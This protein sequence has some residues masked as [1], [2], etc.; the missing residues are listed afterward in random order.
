[1]KM[2]IKRKTSTIPFG[3]KL[4]EDDNR[5][6][7]SVDE[8]LEALDSIVPMVNAK[9][10]SLREGALWLSHKTGRYISHQGLDKIIKKQDVA[11]T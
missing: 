1:M 4:D 7:L 11:T 5:Y 2:R 3:Y 6:L 10:L 9:T 8:E